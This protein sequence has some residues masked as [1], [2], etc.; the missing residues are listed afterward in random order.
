[1]LS[2]Y[3]TRAYPAPSQAAAL[4]VWIGHQRFIYNA[5][6]REA[7]YWRAFGLR[8]LSLTG[9]VPLPDQAYSHFVGADTGFLRDVPSQV[10]RNGAYR[11][12]TGC[13][14]MLKGL[15]GA[16]VIRKRH[17]RQSV[18]LTS[19]LF[20]FIEHTD[21][22]SG[23]A[24]WSLRLGTRSKDLGRLKFKAKKGVPFLP[25]KMLSISL[26]PD[27]RWYVSFCYEL[28]LQR[29]DRVL[30]TQAE[31]AYEFGLLGAAEL[32][33]LTVGID[34]GVML[35]VATSEAQAFTFDPVCARLIA[36]KERQVK[37]HQRRMARQQLGSKNRAKTRQRMARCKGYGANVRQDFA[38]KTSFALVA[39]SAKVFVFEDL[40]LKNMTA[41]PAPKQDAKGRYTA[42]GAAAKAG[43]N[44]ALLSSA[45]GLV[46]QYTAYKAA[47]CNKLVLSVPAHYS[48]QE[49]AECGHTTAENR[50]SQAGFKCVACGH[51]DNADFNAARVLKQRG[52]KAVLD[53]VP[54][55]KPKKT[56][57]VRGKDKVGSVRPEPGESPTPVKSVSA[58]ERGFAAN[59][60]VLG[61][62]GNRH[63]RAMA[64]GG[65]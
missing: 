61:E 17:G 37:R 18:L 22:P 63:L 38:H 50:L 8:A 49:C 34:R 20:R 3:R 33:G 19:E 35:P 46:K 56:A 58:V 55:N 7:D 16:P 62:A 26:E 14:R 13:T 44:K 28:Q 41:A 9:Q 54:A 65:R 25:P 60:A 4:R 43:L 5:K 40:K 23:E 39:S 29:E 64:R 45:L 42:N 32:E 47:R 57:R 10:L 24:Q 2:G 30:R 59:D 11:F 21:A 12:A 31:L 53:G 6:V 1:M 27:G 52:I 48:S 36:R 51:C 15:G